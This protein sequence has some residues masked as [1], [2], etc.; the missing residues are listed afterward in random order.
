MAATE[1]II[2]AIGIFVMGA[3]IGLVAVVSVGIRHEERLF[4]ER[5]QLA[6]EESLMLGQPVS[7][8]GV[9]YSAPGQVSHGARALTGLAVRR[10]R[11]AGS[12]VAPE[13]EP[14]H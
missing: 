7:Y 11:S 9:T 4:R 10:P 1:I 14:Q 3:A 12:L 13:Y 2:I 5:R 6:E 8:L